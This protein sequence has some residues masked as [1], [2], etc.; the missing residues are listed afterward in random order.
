[1]IPPLFKN[2][3]LETDFKLKANFFNKFFA[4]KGTLIQNNSVI[5]KF[6]ECESMNRLTSI[7]FNNESVLKI[8]KAL[9][10]NKTHGHDDISVPMIKLCNK[11][12]ISTIS[13]IYKNCINSG[14]LSTILQKSNVVP[15]H[16][17]GDKQVVDNYRP[18]SLLPVFDKILEK[19]IFS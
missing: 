14:I 4:D 18:V 1:M 11:S 19:L 5:P 7:S 3:K 17:K 10:I 12:I 16:K 8:I 15:V 2:I 9:D 6:I 13:L